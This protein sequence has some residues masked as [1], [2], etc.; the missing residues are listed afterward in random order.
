MATTVNNT[1]V[2]IGSTVT[3]GSSGT[4]QVDFD[5]TGVTGYTDL[6]I[7]ASARDDRG[8][9]WT[10]VYLKFNDSTTNF[11]NRHLYGIGSGSGYG[12]TYS[13]GVLLEGENGSTTT[14][15]VFSNY[16]I[17]IPNYTSSN[18]KSWLVDS[19][20]ENNA[21]TSY[22]EIASGV[23]S[24]TA[25]ITKVSLLLSGSIK[26]VQNS[27]FTLYGITATPST[28]K[29]T[30]G[31]IY[32]DA[33]YM[34]H[35]FPYTSTFTPLASLSCDA[36]VV[37][38]GGSGGAD[39]GGGGGAGGFRSGTSLS[40]SA[41]GYTVTVGAGGAAPYGTAAIAYAGSSSTFSTITSSGGGRGGSRGYNYP[42]GDTGGNGGS[43]GG[44]GGNESG[45]RAGGTG[46]SGGY[47]PVEGNNGG[48]GVGPAGN[49]AGG[50]GGGAGAAGTA[51]SSGTTTGGAG[52][53]GTSSY[54]SWA[55]ATSTGQIV[56]GTGY[57]AGG[58]GGGGG[59]V[60][61]VGGNGGGGA[62]ALATVSGTNGLV[63][64]GGGGGGAGN[65]TNTGYGGSGGSGIVIIRYAK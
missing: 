61:G 52:G 39:S 30:G 15:N 32:Q 50:G 54:S 23:W 26:F 19:V 11:T 21:T 38:G 37:G 2:K 45:S 56:S 53:N 13:T 55:I 47:N 28:T 10:S 6:L 12:T 46:N 48:A 62:G 20:T 34:Y 18:Y 8:A 63:N 27:T 29:A 7:K 42:T 35:V 58:G 44:G 60:A 25:A 51:A 59:T 14:A 40:L 16:E 24:N 17:Y 64:T 49:F 5:L 65:S 9:D 1:M 33:T 4:L 43:G 36:I 22:C 57:Y 3:V 31:I 41:T